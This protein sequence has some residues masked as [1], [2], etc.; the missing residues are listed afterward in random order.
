MGGKQ[1]EQLA[2]NAGHT[3]VNT[4]I[5]AY[6]CVSNY[7][8]VLHKNKTAAKCK[9]ETKAAKQSKTKATITPTPNDVFI[10]THT[11]TERETQQQSLGLR[12]LSEG[13]LMLLLNKESENMYTLVYKEVVD[14]S[15]S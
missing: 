5:Y 14:S 2:R 6:V 3:C 8:N 7:L 9:R 13:S 4:F 12:C 15:A 10:N 1:Q 11:H